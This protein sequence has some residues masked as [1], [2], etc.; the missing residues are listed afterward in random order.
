M[1][2]MMIRIDIGTEGYEVGL[3]TK[4]LALHPTPPFHAFHAGQLSRRSD[5]SRKRQDARGFGTAEDELSDESGTRRRLRWDHDKKQQRRRG[6]PKAPP[7]TRIT[8]DGRRLSAASRA[9]RDELQA[10]VDRPERCDWM[11]PAFGRP[12]PRRR[13]GGRVPCCLLSLSLSFGRLDDVSVGRG[14]E[15]KQ[16]GRG[17]QRIHGSK[18]LP[19]CCSEVEGC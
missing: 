6:V 1:L 15:L 2:W 13:G 5:Y 18:H 14:S 12:V 10:E 7:R 4:N 8:K 9:W 16:E 3:Y 17:E 11:L 19:S